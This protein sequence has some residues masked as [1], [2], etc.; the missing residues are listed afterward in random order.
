MKSVTRSYRIRA[1]PNGVQR[2]WLDRWLGANRWLWNTA[3]EIRTEAYRECALTITGNEIS[4]WLTQ[5]KRTPGHEWLAQVSAT[6]F[7]QCLRDQDR[8][9]N[10]FFA[11]RAR[12]PKFK[13]K[14]TSGSLRFQDAGA[15]W[16]RGIL[17]LPKLGVLKMAES[18]PEVQRPDLVTL[19]RDAAGRYFVSFGAEV[20][21]Q[22]P[23]L[24][25]QCPAVG[26]D[27]GIKH[28]AAL[29]TG[30][31]IENPRHYQAGLRYLRQQ[32]RCLSRRQKGSRRR[33]RQRLKVARAH[34]KVKQ[35][36]G[37]ALHALTTRLTQEFDLIFIEDLNVKGMARGRNAR[38]I[39]DAA[40]GEVRRQLTYKSDWRHKILI[41][42]DRWYPSSKT[43]S[44]CRHR[45]DELRLDVREWKCPK[46]GTLH[47]RDINAAR[48]LLL[49]GF[50]QLAGRDDRDLCVDAGGACPDEDILVQVLADEAR[51]GQRNRAWMEQA[52][53][54]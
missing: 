31:K 34:A 25:F 41:E 12:Y 52:S 9:F 24:S 26:V 10:N 3:L 7:T 33:E 49:E 38:S 48:N 45:L 40:F 43:C 14:S 46:C 47:D 30:E 2:R 32:Q 37:Y 5:W 36:R 8:A 1:Y 53:F 20:E 6:C 4:R 44:N 51:S 39:H 21:K 42:V 15:A 54:C 17:S 28:L 29:S 35:E 22:P 11:G 19:S 18:L 13:R 50:R 23:S 27:L 16:R